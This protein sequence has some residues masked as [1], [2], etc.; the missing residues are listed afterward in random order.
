MPYGNFFGIRYHYRETKAGK[1]FWIFWYILFIGLT[2]VTLVCGVALFFG[3]TFFFQGALPELQLEYDSLYLGLSGAAF[4]ALFWLI[5]LLISA[6]RWQTRASTNQSETPPDTGYAAIWSQGVAGQH[7]GHST[8]R[9][10]SATPHSG[11][12]AQASPRTPKVAHETQ[13]SPSGIAEAPGQRV[14]GEIEVSADTPKAR[15]EELRE[16][17]TAGLIT[18]QDYDE[19]KKEIIGRL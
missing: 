10:G 13:T 11:L 5:P 3:V 1:G 2:I 18:Q 19:K 9:A 8:A 16:M 7:P 4:F 15:L 17:L 6:V 14:A 12:T